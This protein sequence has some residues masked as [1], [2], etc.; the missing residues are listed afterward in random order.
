MFKKALLPLLISSAMIIPAAN[1][2]IEANVEHY[3]QVQ[4][5][6]PVAGTVMTSGYAKVVAQSAYVWGWTLV[7]MHNR[8]ET[9]KEV[10][11]HGYLDGSMPVA[12][13]NRL[14]M[15][16]DY[17]NPYQ[18]DVAHP[19]QD[20][21]YGWGVLS[22]DIEP[23]VVQVPDFGDRYWTVMA[24]D[25]RT[26]SFA[27]IGT[28]HNSEPGF[29]MLAG[30]NWQ[31][32]VPKGVKQVFRSSTDMGV[33]IPRIFMDDS[34][35]DRAVVQELAKEVMA[36][37][38]SEYDGTMREMDWAGLPSFPDPSADQ[39]K[40]EKAW[41]QPDRFFDK[42]QLGAVLRDVPPMPGEEAMYAQF[43]A[44]I[45]EA[46]KNPALKKELAGIAR[47]TEKNIIQPLMWFDNV[48]AEL[49]HYWTQPQ[50]NGR[51][52]TDYLTRLAVA[53]SNI[54]TNDISETSYMYQYRD[55]NG[56]RLNG[57][58]NYTITFEKDELPPI[59]KNGFWS[60]TM[61]DENHFFQPNRLGRFSVGTKNKDL[62]F[63]KDGSLTIYIQNQPPTQDKVSNWLPAPEGKLAMTIRT[64][65]PKDE[66]FNGEWTPPAVK[67]VSL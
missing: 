63:N 44:L 48:G 32:E 11:V 47:D 46:E 28:V 59:I 52:G 13:I 21:I 30:P 22:L 62:Q 29:Y 58:K 36:Y 17:A 33:V 12:P 18:R 55:E 2:S 50:N 49:D 27:E 57:N 14:T 38:L 1:A 24:E 61:Y 7:N 34:N 41:V 54:F 45:E 3:N 25:Q 10:P 53:R 60:L 19:N 40:G 16:M 43:Q 37:P 64:Y 5:A 23:V 26:D 8:R 35:E 9:F 51:F 6:G 56:E 65:G 4:P 20:V 67:P 39:T 15:L 31:G 42:D 66:A